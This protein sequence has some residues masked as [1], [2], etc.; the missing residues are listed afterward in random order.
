MR[1]ETKGFI[2]IVAI[3]AAAL[4]L[5]FVLLAAEYATAQT[6][7][8][9]MVSVPA[10][11]IY[12]RDVFLTVEVSSDIPCSEAVG[13]YWTTAV[14]EGWNYAGATRD[15]LTWQ[16]P[17]DD[18]LYLFSSQVNDDE[19]NPEEYHQIKAE[20]F[21]CMD[22]IPP[23]D[24]PECPGPT[25]LGS[26]QYLASEDILEWGTASTPTVEWWWLHPTTGSPVETYT[27]QFISVSQEGDTT[28][29][30]IPGLAEMDSLYGY[31]STPYP[32]EGQR[33]QVRVAGVDSLDRQG[34]FSVWS[35]PFGDD[36]PPGE[37]GQPQGHLKLVK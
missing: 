13:I 12:G 26:V 20:V 35:A 22:C 5:V 37:T 30:Q 21:T 6:P 17:M 11:T 3:I 25:I 32:M 14:M 18:T 31:G 1:T 8:V 36:G 34:V 4:V 9:S 2:S 33:Q 7:P 23:E 28:F 29:A 10:D 15:T 19:G 24:C 27:M 16:A